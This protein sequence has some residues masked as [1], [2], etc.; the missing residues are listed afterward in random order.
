MVDGFSS[1]AWFDG[2]EP[3]QLEVAIQNG[4]MA[5]GIGL[6]DTAIRDGC[7]PPTVAPETWLLRTG[8]QRKGPLSLDAIPAS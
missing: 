5:G 7:N 3:G 4:R 8:W 1:A 6:L 2:F